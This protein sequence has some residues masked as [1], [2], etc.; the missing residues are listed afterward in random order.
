MLI[1]AVYSL[2]ELV[3]SQRASSYAARLLTTL[4]TP[5]IIL[6]LWLLYAFTLK[7]ILLPLEP[8]ELPYWVPSE[9]S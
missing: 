5:S 9:Y 3:D 2:Q 1:E 6:L 7:P 4:S 8:R